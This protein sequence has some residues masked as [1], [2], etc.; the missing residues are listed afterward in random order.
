MDVIKKLCI[1]LLCLTG[2]CALIF[3]IFPQIDLQIAAYFYSPE[4]G[5]YTSD[6]P[7]CIAIRK[8]MNLLTAG[9]FFLC[10]GGVFFARSVGLKPQPFELGALVFLLGPIL[11]VNGILKTF[12]GRAR[13]IQIT[14][15]G[16]ERMF[17]PFYQITDQCARNCTFVSGEGA[18]AT[19]VFIAVTLLAVFYLKGAIRWVC[20]G[21]AF[22]LSTFAAVLRVGFGGH[23]TSDVIFSI[24]FVLLILCALMK[25]KRYRNL[26]A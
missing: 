1:L 17:T 3:A 26:F 22:S 7:I 18:A 12:W 23:F 9:V 4:V 14:E 19:A 13:P 21:V 15:F 8:A 10:I 20:I 11:L 16:G 5:F 6:S 2:I 24:L 25:L